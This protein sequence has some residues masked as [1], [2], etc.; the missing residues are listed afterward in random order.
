MTV[1]VSVYLG[2]YL[3][4]CVRRC[5]ACPVPLLRLQ[6]LLKLAVLVLVFPHVHMRNVKNETNVGAAM[7]HLQKHKKEERHQFR[8]VGG[9][10][11]QKPRLLY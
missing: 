5:P 11:S 10:P 7:P 4:F 6:S 3:Q 8:R 2:M 9:Y 1:V